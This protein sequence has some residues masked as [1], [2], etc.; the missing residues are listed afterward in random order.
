MNQNP[1]TCEEKKKSLKFAD[2]AAV[3]ASGCYKE[4][5]N[6]KTLTCADLVIFETLFI[7]VSTVS[8]AVVI[9]K[10]LLDHWSCAETHKMMCCTG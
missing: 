3:K 8:V 9:V 6:L 2:T 7:S 5:K 4:S 1:E 10:S